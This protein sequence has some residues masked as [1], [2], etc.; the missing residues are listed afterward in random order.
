MKKILKQIEKAETACVRADGECGKLAA[1]LMPYFKK[2][3]CEELFVFDQH[4]DGLVVVLFD[5]NYPVSDVIRCIEAGYTDLD[6]R[7]GY[8]CPLIGI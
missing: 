7:D 8:D 4:G 3:I 1:M 6:P 2:D 5:T